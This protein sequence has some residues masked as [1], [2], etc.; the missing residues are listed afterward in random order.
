[1][2]GSLNVNGNGTVR[3]PIPGGTAERT[4][5]VADTGAGSAEITFEALGAKRIPF[6]LDSRVARGGRQTVRVSDLEPGESVQVYLRG[7][8]VDR[9]TANGNG[10]FNARFPVGQTLGK[11][12]VKV[13]G[14]FADTR[15]NTHTFTV[16]R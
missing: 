6:T 10:R 9:G 7:N 4:F 2:A 5:T 16:T 12:Q 3:V 14:E 8:R 1:M 13:T 15:K 11:A